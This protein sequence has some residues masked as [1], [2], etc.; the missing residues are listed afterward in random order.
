MGTIILEWIKNKFLL[1]STGSYIQYS[2]INYNQKEYIK[3]NA[4]ICRT[5][6]LCCTA[7]IYNS[8]NQLYINKK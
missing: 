2:V 5:E 3:K 4:S 7:E 1:Y 8:V 6:S